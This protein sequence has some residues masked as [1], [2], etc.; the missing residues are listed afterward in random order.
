MGNQLE[1]DVEGIAR[2]FFDD[3]DEGR[4]LDL[5]IGSARDLEDLV[6]TTRL[7]EIIDFKVLLSPNEATAKLMH[8]YFVER[9][10]GIEVGD[11]FVGTYLSLGDDGLRFDGALTSHEVDATTS[12]CRIERI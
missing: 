12:K 4:E 8:K 10:D 9:T 6:V 3:L 1:A 7:Y 11:I 5:Q 2:N